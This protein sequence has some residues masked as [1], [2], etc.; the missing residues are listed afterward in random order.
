MLDL[1]TLMLILNQ[2][3]LAL[4][5][6]SNRNVSSVTRSTSGMLN[7]V[8]PRYQCSHFPW[9]ASFWPDLANRMA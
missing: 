5:S 3:N 6:S 7:L 9:L 1:Y 8:S 2:F 4:C